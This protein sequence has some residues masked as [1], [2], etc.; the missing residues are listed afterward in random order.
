MTKA[1]QIEK[2][3]VVTRSTDSQPRIRMSNQM[4]AVLKEKAL[5]NGRTFNNEIL[6]RLAKT[7]YDDQGLLIKKGENDEN[8]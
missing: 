3:R 2:W 8:K 5:E 4:L 1:V 7:L 6:Y